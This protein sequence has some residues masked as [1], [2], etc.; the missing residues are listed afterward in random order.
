MSFLI[1]LL[2][3]AASLWAAVELVPGIAY[4]GGWGGLLIVAL[5]FGAV[6]ALVRPILLLL[7]CPLVLITLGLFVFVLNALMLSLTGAVAQ[8]FGVQFTVDGFLSALVGSIIVSI[9]STALTIVVGDKNKK[10]KRRDD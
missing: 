10:K 2:I 4:Q 9:V 1:R 7:T 6:N 5:I 8:S 3:T